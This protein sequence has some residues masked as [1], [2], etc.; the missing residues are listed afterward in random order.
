VIDSTRSVLHLSI[1]QIPYGAVATAA[2]PLFS[3]G[4]PYVH[5]QSTPAAS[6]AP[7]AEVSKIVPSAAT[8]RPPA[9]S[10]FGTLRRSATSLVVQIENRASDPGRLFGT[11]RVD[12]QHGRCGHVKVLDWDSSLE[13]LVCSRKRRKGPRSVFPTLGHTGPPPKVLLSP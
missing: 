8:L 13:P 1:I 4:K 3:L 5:T 11:D 10:M 6:S 7:L 9:S 12:V 2:A